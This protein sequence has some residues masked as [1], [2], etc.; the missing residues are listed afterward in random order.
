MDD[1]IEMTCRICLTTDEDGNFKPIT[2]NSDVMKKAKEMF[3]IENAEP[4]QEAIICKQCESDL[5]E[6]YKVFNRI[7]DANDYF[8]HFSGKKKIAQS[9]NEQVPNDQAVKPKTIKKPQKAM[10]PKSKII[11][12]CDSCKKDFVS[13]EQ[14]NEHLVNQ[15]RN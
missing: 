6:A 1:F 9:S 10:K 13:M 14:L 11:F 4:F 3:R 5:N 12:E 7:L 8:A 2:E 15:H